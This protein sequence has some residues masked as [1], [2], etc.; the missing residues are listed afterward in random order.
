M[1][2]KTTLPNGLRLIT[3]NSA[4]TDTV[5]VLTLVGTG[6]KYETKEIS[7][8]SH[9]LEHLQFKG[10]KKRLTE[11]AVFSEIDGLG[12]VANAFTSQEMT[13]YY[14]KVQSKK[15]EAAFDLVADIFLNSTLPAPEIEKERGTIIEELNMF[16]DHPMRYIWTVWNGALYGDQP[17]GW[18]IG[19]TIET[20]NQI[21]RDQLLDYRDKNY[22]AKN[23][24]ICVSGNFDAVGAEILAKKY[25]GDFSAK[26]PA[27][28][29]P[30]RESQSSPNVL[31]YKKDT[32]QTQIAL[33]AR[34]FDY[35][36]PKRYAL[37]LLETILGGMFSS[38]LAEEVRFKRGLVYDVHTELAMDSDSGSLAATANLDSARLDEGI[39]VISS[40]F[41]KIREVKVSADELRKAKDHYIGKSSIV[42][43]SS[44]AKG[45]FYGEQE[46]LEGRILE[47]EEIY[48]KIK[49]VTVD[50]IQEA[51]RD[52]FKPEKLNLAVIGPYDGKSRF[53]KL[54]DNAL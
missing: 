54:L 18:D 52:I 2:K 23:T 17:A 1:Y 15:F 39:K 49:Q 27:K 8:I 40:E 14:A 12:G 20:V 47:P 9:F 51:A 53:Q 48:E 37:E 44:H 6:S 33:G 28:K 10:T 24:I 4:N 16:Y 13:G 42:L 38:R 11:M 25:F 41:K 29:M 5:T 19:G 32:N 21:S 50:D 46:L 34:A 45:L 36:Y 30:V 43:E 7:G 31:I 26:D 3:V 22:A 35:S